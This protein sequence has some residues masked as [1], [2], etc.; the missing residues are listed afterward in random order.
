MALL[1]AL[2]KYFKNFDRQSIQHALW[3]GHSSCTRKGDTCPTEPT[4]RD[5]RASFGMLNEKLK[6]NSVGADDK[7]DTHHPPAV[8][9]YIASPPLPQ[10]QQGLCP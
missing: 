4:K 5:E 2:C 8:G 6:D 1:V 3:V 7:F 9:M 10:R